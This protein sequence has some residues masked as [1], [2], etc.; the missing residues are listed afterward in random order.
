LSQDLFE[1]SSS[2]SPVR[3]AARAREVRFTVGAVLT[4]AVVAA[5]GS[6]T[7][8]NRTIA[9][10]YDTHWQRTAADCSP[11]ALPAPTESNLANY[12]VA[13]ARDTQ[14]VS[15]VDIAVADT[16]LTF[17]LFDGSGAQDPLGPYIGDTDVG[18]GL[19]TRT[20]GP[21]TE[22]LRGA[23]RFSATATTQFNYYVL[24][25]VLT[26]PGQ[27]LQIE[28]QISSTTTYVYSENGT[29]FTTCVAKDVGSAERFTG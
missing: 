19:A 9:G 22:G 18:P 21:I 16:S 14:W 17:T 12:L 11:V 15:K 26:A 4:L 5:C 28:L 13:P 2:R 23:H 10:S 24:P 25:L 8:P 7:E 27:G 20:R 29:V 6:S 3:S 1:S